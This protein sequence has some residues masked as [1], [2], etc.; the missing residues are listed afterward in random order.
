MFLL[1][2]LVDSYVHFAMVEAESIERRREPIKRTTSNLTWNILWPLTP[3]K[4]HFWGK[5]RRKEEEVAGVVYDTGQY[6]R[7]QKAIPP[8]H[9]NRGAVGNWTEDRWAETIVEHGENDRNAK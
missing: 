7:S 3:P 5:K 8:I 4:T 2:A 6:S 1:D 9:N